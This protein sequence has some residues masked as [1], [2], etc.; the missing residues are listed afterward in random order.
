MS[1]KCKKKT[2]SYALAVNWTFS[3]QPTLAPSPPATSSFTTHAWTFH[4]EFGTGPTRSIR[5]LF[6][7]PC[8]TTTV[9][10]LVMRV[11]TLAMASPS[12]AP[13][14]ISTSTLDALPCPKPRRE[15]IT[16]IRLLSSIPS[17]RKINWT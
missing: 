3:A 12:I 8:L 9:S 14:A 17:Q 15:K 13:R 6:S 4:N 1:Q 2:I 5:S 11:V 16:I 10:S 7:H